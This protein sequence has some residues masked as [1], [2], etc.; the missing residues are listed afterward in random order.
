MTARQ[1]SVFDLAGIGIGPFNLGL[2]ALLEPL[3]KV[4]FIFFDS[5]PEF[6]WHPGMLL[7]DTHLQVPF[8]ADLVT[9]ADPTSPYSFLNYLKHQNRLYRFYFYE[10]F[11]IPRAEYDHY[12]KWVAKQIE[13]CR[14]NET[15]ESVNF[16]EEQSCFEIVTTKA[17]YFACNLAVGTGTKPW[18]PEFLAHL[19]QDRIVHTS[20]FKENRQALANQDRLYVVGSGQSAAEAF[21]DLARTRR[22][23]QKIAWV[24]RS[25]GFLPM[26]YSKLG[27]A[28]YFSP[29]YMKFFHGIDQEKKDQ[30]LKDQDL[31]YKG[32]SSLTIAQIYDLLYEDSACGNNPAL[33]L[34]PYHELTSCVQEHNSYKLKFKHTWTGDKYETFADAM[35]MGTGYRHGIPPML[36][37]LPLEFDHKERL[38]V[39]ASHQVKWRHQGKAAIFAQNIEIHSH[40]VGTPDLGLGA[41]R[42]SQIVNQLLGQD[43]YTT[44]EQAGFHRFTLGP[45]SAT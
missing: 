41:Y 2:A 5:Q 22:P 12:C 19:P 26:E 43:Y 32:I 20:R 45:R 40:G 30:L 21:L 37:G 29:D 38:V 3:E 34:I 1:N 16:I 33:E 17:R 39:D 10:S 13:Q 6:H 24:T 28:Q 27:L 36:Y 23:E 44:P 35:V 7:P 15:V 31:L 18:I 11:H 25:D 42:N 14:F 4:N 9:M 8:L